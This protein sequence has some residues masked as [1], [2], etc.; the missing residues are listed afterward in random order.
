MKKISVLF[1]SLLF[2]SCSSIRV[3]SD[4]DTTINFDDYTTYAFFKPG[5]DEVEISD[6]DKKR[7]L[8]AIE[9]EMEEKQFTKSEN[10]E[11]LINIAVKSSND[12]YVNS[13]IAF[14]LG[15]GW[16]AWGWNAWG[17]PQ[18]N[19]VTINSQ[20]NGLLLIDIIDTK[21]KKLIWQGKGK[22]YISEFTRNRDERIQCFVT[23]IL[24]NYPPEKE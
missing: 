13:N 24:K 3:M 1:I 15:W 12:V 8:L 7:I 2:V 11:L 6:L 19:A 5:I 23:E 4:Y 20:T 17:G 10:P 18:L 22:G 9:K 21:T 14:G 16:N